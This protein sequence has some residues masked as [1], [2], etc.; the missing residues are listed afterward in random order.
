MRKKLKAGERQAN[1]K[2]EAFMRER[3]TTRNFRETAR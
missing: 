2:K 1:Q 3:K